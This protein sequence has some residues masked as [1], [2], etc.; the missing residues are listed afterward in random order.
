[1][2]VC[3]CICNLILIGIKWILQQVNVEL[4]C[5]RIVLRQ[6]YIYIGERMKWSIYIYCFKIIDETVVSLFCNSGHYNMLILMFSRVSNKWLWN[7]ITSLPHNRR[8]TTTLSNHNQ[9]ITLQI[10]YWLVDILGQREWITRINYVTQLLFLAVQFAIDNWDCY[11]W[12]YNC[13]IWI[14]R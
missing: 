14:V 1:M 5:E 2:C 4:K 8:E 12:F 13:V 3:I 6:L 11:S 10:F 9:I 7:I